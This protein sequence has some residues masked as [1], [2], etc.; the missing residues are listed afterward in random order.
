[1]HP[2]ECGFPTGV[3]S[4]TRT[5]LVSRKALNKLA[6]VEL[7]TLSVFRRHLSSTI[8]THHPE[9][10][11]QALGQH[12][13][14]CTGVVGLHGGS[15]ASCYVVSANSTWQIP[16]A[17]RAAAAAA[18]AMRLRRECTSREAARRPNHTPRRREY[19]VLWDRRRE[20]RRRWSRSCLRACSPVRADLCPKWF[21]K[22]S[23]PGFEAP[24]SLRCVPPA[25][26]PVPLVR[27]S[28]DDTQSLGASALFCLP[29]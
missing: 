16:A 21:S 17:E 13:R 19:R 3:L 1:M 29:R 4:N 14:E 18:S 26:Q 9:A 27:A 5:R 10:R 20:R 11:P 24:I 25:R 15:E 2:G 23:S 22:R 8:G 6:R 7:P 28:A 12:R